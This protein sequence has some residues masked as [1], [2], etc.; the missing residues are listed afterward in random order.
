MSSN[1]SKELND[2]LPVYEL[3][4]GLRPF[5]LRYVALS[6]DRRECVL[7]TTI[8]HPPVIIVIGDPMVESSNVLMTL[9]DS[10]CITKT[11]FKTTW[12]AR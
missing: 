9:D 5:F 11:I 1:D 3:R 7:T 10:T 12:P 6:A 8:G 2:F 4:R